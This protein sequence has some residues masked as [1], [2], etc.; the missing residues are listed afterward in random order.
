VVGIFPNENAVVLVGTILLEQAGEWAFRRT[1]YMSLETIS[2]LSD[3]PVVSLPA[4]GS[5]PEQT[6]RSW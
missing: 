1:R 4:I 5:G 3:D 2:T 6:R